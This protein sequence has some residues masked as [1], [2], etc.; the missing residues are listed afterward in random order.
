MNIPGNIKKIIKELSEAGYEAFVVGGCVRDLILKKEP[1]DWDVTTSAKPEEIL[2][3]F[4]DGRYENTFGTIIVPFKDEEG[5]LIE[6]VE[7]TTYR[8]EQ[9]YS[10]RRHPDEVRFEEDID[11]DLERRD[12]TVNALA[13]SLGKIDEKYAK[14]ILKIEGFEVL[15]FFGGLKDIEKKILRA[16]GEPSDRFKEDA[17]RMMRAIRFACEL[18]FEIEPKTLRA[19]GKL[20]GNIKFISNER[21]RDEF[22]KIIKSAKG[23]SG[24]ELM[25]EAN[26]LRYVIPELEEGVKVD[27]SRHHIYTVF[28]HLVKS[29][30]HCPSND[31]RV[32]L[33]CLMHDIGKPR[34]HKIINGIATFYNHEYAGAKMAYRIMNRL[35]FSNKDIEKITLL[36]KNHMFYYN[37]GQV[38]ATSVRRLIGKVGEE[39][40]KDLIDLRIG[41]RLGSGTPKAKPYKLRHLEYMMDRVRKDPV[42]VKMLKVNGDDIIKLLKIQPSPKIGFILDC[43]LA[44][45]I[46]G[47]ELNTK[48]YLVEEAIK[49]NKLDNDSLRAQAKAVIEAER[50]KEDKAMK[51]NYY[52]K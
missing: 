52:V 35:K 32:K 24:I 39:N 34:T 23:H 30:E 40:L 37:V 28:K 17:L 18:D 42:S 26:L 49:L 25:Q 6:E 44:K 2:K 8:S 16:V 9:G 12:F 3:I 29:L 10:D 4:S 31:W 5:E 21:K 14:Y 45:V 27:Q 51:Q 33:A 46:E 36:I 50:E 13:L 19:V 20:A 11:K 22:I 38:T 41:D 7:I 48:E 15:D 47:P 1:K 43:L